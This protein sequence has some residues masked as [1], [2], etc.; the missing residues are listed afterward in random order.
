MLTVFRHQRPTLVI[1]CAAFHH[2]DHC[3]VQPERAFAVNAL[4]V[5]RLAAAA[6]CVGAAFLTVSTDYV[7]DGKLT[8]RPYR[9]DDAPNPLSVYGASKYAGELLARRHSERT[10]IVRTSGLYGRTGSTVK[11]YTFIDRVLKQAEAGEP[12]R[13]VDDVVFSPSYAVDVARALRRL[14]ETGRFG[15][16]H[17]TNRGACSWYEFAGEAFRLSGISPDFAPI[18]YNGF[19]SLVR[20]PMH[21]PLEHAALDAL[22]VEPVPHWRDGLAEYLLA[23]TASVS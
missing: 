22:G 16:Y 14:I 12:V 20:R 11:G 19:G 4:A 18:K 13:V 6:A 3:E 17:V 23:R 10:F 8:T 2:V 7:F 9:E 21:S 1:N 15:L 5:D